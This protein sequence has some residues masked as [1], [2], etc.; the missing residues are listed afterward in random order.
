MAAA[1]VEANRW[2]LALAR[3]AA[4]TRRRSPT[5]AWRPD[6][7]DAAERAAGLCRVTGL[8]LGWLA[9]GRHAG[10]PA[11][12]LNTAALPGRLRSRRRG[13]GRSGPRRSGAASTGQREEI[14]VGDRI[15][16]FLP[17][18]ALGDQRV[19]IGREG[20]RV[21]LLE[22]ADGVRVLLAAEDELF[23]LLPLRRMFPHRHDDGHHDGHDA[24]RHQEGHHRVT[25]LVPC[26]S[27][28]TS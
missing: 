22:E 16:E 20:V 19:E 24:H 17:Q 6:V 11:G 8:T 12:W 9:G 5:G 14:V 1:V 23:F 4:D 13:P 21:L 27:G 7:G 18:K 26:R 3:D 15:L 28:L 25:P 10:S 2:I